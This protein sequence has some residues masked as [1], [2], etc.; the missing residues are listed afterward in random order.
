MRV[1]DTA[2]VRM[3]KQSQPY[4]FLCGCFKADG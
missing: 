1:V 3:Y 4:R 2:V